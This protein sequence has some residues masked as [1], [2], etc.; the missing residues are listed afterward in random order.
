MD[1]DLELQGAIVTTLKADP[2]VFALVGGRVY[3]RV[4]ED[5]VFPYITY[6]PTD[7][8]TDDYECLTGFQITVQIDVWSRDYGFPECKR[9]N[10]AV[11]VALH[12]V[13]LTLNTNALVSILHEI[14]RTFRDPDGETNHGAVQF[15]ASIEKG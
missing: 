8:V 13:N 2:A 9:I 7:S 14:T 1:P 15:G 6:G 3:D 5:P 4:P 10:D 11:R 12:D